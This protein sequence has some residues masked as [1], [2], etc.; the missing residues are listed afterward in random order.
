MKL[1]NLL[2]LT[3]LTLLSQ[4]IFAKSSDVLP[5][6]VVAQPTTCI[7]AA[8][9]S[10]GDNWWRT[11]TLRLTNNCGK[12]VDFQN[13][14]VTF[15]NGIPLNTNFWGDFSPLPYPDNN[16]QI[17]SQPQTN[18]KFLTSL[19]MHFPTFPGSNT[20][21]PANSSIAIKYGARTDAHVE[22][23]T[24]VYV[25][26]LPSTGQI[27]LTNL[28]T[29][30]DNV[31]QD[32]AMVHI[33]TNGENISDVQLPWMSAKTVAGLIPGVYAL[34]ADTISAS[35]GINYQG[36]VTPATV[37]VIENQTAQ[38]QV[39]YQRVEQT[40]KIAIK[41]QALPSELSGYTNNPTVMVNQS[42]GSSSKPITLD[43]NTT[44]IVSQLL[45]GAA[46]TF[47][48]P[49]INFNNIKCSPTFTPSTLTA[50]EIPS[51]T[52]LTYSCMDVT[53]SRVILNIKGA[54]TSLPSLR[55]T[56]TPNDQSTRTTQTIS[57]TNGSGSGTVILTTGM[58]YTLAADYVPQYSVSFLPQ[59]LTAS[60]SA[61]VAIT[62]SFMGFKH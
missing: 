13:T 6:I 19:N 52:N 41:L 43:W 32:Y 28:T 55:I 14:T 21:L 10:V 4:T 62:L 26:N 27:Q 30:P 59:P 60:N 42:G 53:K 33:K 54:P 2:G 22:G 44:S 1:T 12:P 49:V 36:T 46:Y 20:N 50:S 8:F 34:S 17:T 7:G 16:L 38:A 5:P 39:A 18:G 57:L 24:K 29:K 56:F 58:I 15:V 47:S 61:N 11:I 40:G 9:S 35:N 31:A 37:D 23:T 51:T 48:T 3:I 45:N 25:G